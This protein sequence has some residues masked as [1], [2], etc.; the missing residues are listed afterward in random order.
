ME[1]IT[2]DYD[3]LADAL[4]KRLKKQ[5]P[6][7]VALWDKADCADYLKQSQRTFLDK[8]SKNHTFPASINVPNGV[9]GKSQSCWYAHEVIKW[10]RENGR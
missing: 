7:E 4:A 6:I 8:T 2:F 1:A 10:V 5:V 3:K 9:G